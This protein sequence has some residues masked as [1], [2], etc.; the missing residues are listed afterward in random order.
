MNVLRAIPDRREVASWINKMFQF[1][2][3]ESKP[4]DDDDG[5]HIPLYPLTFPLA[6]KP[7]HDLVNRFIY[8]VWDRQVI[9]YGEIADVET[10]KSSEAIHVGS[11]ANRRAKPVNARAAL[12]LKAP[13]LR[14][15][16]HIAA[17]GFQGIR[18]IKQDLHSITQ[19]SAQRAVAAAINRP[20]K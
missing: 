16:F 14:M 10:F 7:A 5:E 12:V 15:P 2:N 18:Y 9:G 13:L 4:S 1:G 17:T 6:I 20:I 19:A 3:A 11:D 8:V